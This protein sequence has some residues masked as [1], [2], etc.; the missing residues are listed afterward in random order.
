M[1]QRTIQC[2]MKTMDM[3]AVPELDCLP[4]PEPVDILFLLALT[5]LIFHLCFTEFHSLRSSL[6]WFL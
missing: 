1:L 2:A 6:M 3:V 5:E 4:S